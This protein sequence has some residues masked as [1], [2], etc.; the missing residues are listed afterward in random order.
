MREGGLRGTR[1]GPRA[2]LCLSRKGMKNPLLQF[3]ILFNP[4]KNI[5]IFFSLLMIRDERY[6]FN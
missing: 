6:R 4:G 3:G 5:N 1:Q 2:P